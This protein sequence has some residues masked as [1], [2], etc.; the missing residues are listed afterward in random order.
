MATEVEEVQSAL[1]KARKAGDD[2]AVTAL[3]RYRNRIEQRVEQA[4]SPAQR[5]GSLPS[6]RERPKRPTR[7]TRQ[8]QIEKEAWEADS[9]LPRANP[10]Q[11]ADFLREQL[12]TPPAGSAEQW[13]GTNINR[14]IVMDP[15][16]GGARW[17]ALS[18]ERLAQ[19]QGQKER[20]KGV[21]AALKS[22]FVK[23]TGEAVEVLDEAVKRQHATQK[24]IFMQLS[25]SAQERVRDTLKLKFPDKT[26]ET[27]SPYDFRKV[28]E[29]NPDNA[30][31]LEEMVGDERSVESTEFWKRVGNKIL[32]LRGGIPG[33]MDFFGADDP[34]GDLIGPGSFAGLEY[35][36]SEKEP[37]YE[38]V[39][40]DIRDWKYEAG[41]DGVDLYENMIQPFF[42]KDGVLPGA[43]IQAA[44]DKIRALGYTPGQRESVE[45]RFFP[46]GKGLEDIFT[47]EMW[48]D[49]NT[50]LPWNDWDGFLLTVAENA[51]QI[52]VG[53]AASYVGGGVAARLSVNATRGSKLMEI[54]KARRRAAGLGG[55]IAGG[56]TEGI[57]IHDNVAAEVRDALDEVPMAK[58]EA[59]TKFQQL[60]TAG[61]TPEEAKQ[62]LVREAAS[63]AG[64]AAF[65]FAGVMAGSPMGYF[66]GQ[67][68]A[69]RIGGKFAAS[70]IAI[71]ALGEPFQEGIQ[72][73]IEGEQSD[74]A[75]A[76]IDP[77]NPIFKDKNRRL[78]RFAGGFFIS[79][80][81][82][83]GALGAIEPSKPAGLSKEDQ[84]VMEKTHA[85]MTAADERYKHEIRIS[86][87]AY[88]KATAPMQRLAD[89]EKLEK[90]QKKEAELLLKAEPAMRTYFN[91]EKTL[92]S[93]AETKM[94]NALKMRANATLTD[95]AVA[96]TRRT[97]VAEMV[98]EQQ[99]ILDERARIQSEVG[100][101][102]LRL[103]DVQRLARN[104]EKVQN[105]E[106][107]TEENYA[108]LR[109][110][111]YGTWRGPNKERFVIL[112]KGKRALNL[113][114]QQE[115]NLTGKL[116]AGF[117]GEEKRTPEGALTRELVE[118]AGPA[119]RD[120][121]LYTD[122]LT[123]AGNRRAFDE[124]QKL[125]GEVV[126]AVDV[127]S[128]AWINDNMTHASGDRALMSIAD[129]LAKQKGVKVYRVG[130]DEFA[131]TGASEE[132]VET[133]LQ[134]AADELSATPVVAEGE[135]VTPQITW[136]KGP[137]YA[138]ADVQA[139]SMKADRVRR[140]IIAPRKAKPATHKVRAQ[141]PLLQRTL[142]RL[143]PGGKTKVR[144]VAG[145]Q[146]IYSQ[147]NTDS[148]DVPT[149]LADV[150]S[151]DNLPEVTTVNGVNYIPA[152]WVMRQV[153]RARAT[154]TGRS[155][156]GNDLLTSVMSSVT[157]NNSV[158]DEPGAPNNVLSD[159]EQAA[160][161]EA[162]GDDVRGVKVQNV[163]TVFDAINTIASKYNLYADPAQWRLHYDENIYYEE[164][165]L[166]NRWSSIRDEV[167]RGDNV[168]VLT[169]DGAIQAVVTNVSRRRKRPRVTV[170]IGGRQF[171]F[172]PLR[173]HLITAQSSRADIAWITGDP[174]YVQPDRETIPQ[175][176]T[177]V[178]I[179]HV[180]RQGDWYADLGGDYQP[181][182]FDTSTSLDMY[183]AYWE[184]EYPEWSRATPYVY[185]APE[186]TEEEMEQA[187]TVLRKITGGFKNLPEI[188]LVGSIEEL[189]RINPE[190]VQKLKD[191]PGASLNSVRGFFDE[192][193]PDNGVVILVQN[194]HGEGKWFDA[195]IA[196]TIFHELIG[197]YGVRGVFGNEAEM[198][199]HMHSIVDAFPKVAKR[200]AGS[201]PRQ[202]GQ[203]DEEYKQLLG[204]EM[205]AYITGEML[206]GTIELT[207]PQRTVIQRFFDWI[208]EWFT[209]HG[210]GNYFPAPDKDNLYGFWTD[211]K[212]QMLI[213][214]AQ[215]FVRN[216]TGWSFDYLDGRHVMLMRDADI[217]QLG[218]ITAINT[219]T[220]KLSKGERT[221]LQKKYPEGQVA[222][223][224][225]PLFP[226]I[227]SPNVWKQ[228]VIAAFKQNLM[229]NKELELTKLQEKGQ[230]GEEA[231]WNFFTDVTYS[232]IKLLSGTIATDP[233]SDVVQ[234]WYKEVMPFNLAEEFEELLAIVQ[235]PENYVRPDDRAQFV[236]DAE[237]RIAEILSSKIDQKKSQLSRAHLMA[238][239]GSD[240]VVTV[241]VIPSEGHALLNQ[242]QASERLFGSEKGRN[243]YGEFDLLNL[244]EV[245]QEMVKHEINASRERGYDIGFDEDQQEWFD[246]AQRHAEYGG[247]T[248]E[249]ANFAEDYRVVFIKQRG[250][251]LQMGGSGHFSASETVGV[252][253]HV[254]TGLAE[255]LELEGQ[256]MPIAMH[257]LAANRV[258]S[259]VEQQS[260]WLQSLRKSYKNEDEKSRA[261]H[262]K[263]V[264]AASIRSANKEM[265]VAVTA[266]F[267]ARLTEMLLP[268]ANLPEGSLTSEFEKYLL[269]SRGENVTDE[270]RQD[271]YKTFRN[272]KVGDVLRVID[273]MKAII[274]GYTHNRDYPLRG[275][276]GSLDARAFDLL[277]KF[278][279]GEIAGQ[280]WSDLDSLVPRIRNLENMTDQARFVDWMRD[281]VLNDSLL[282]MF[283]QGMLSGMD[284]GADLRLPKA[285]HELH[286][287][288]TEFLNAMGIADVESKVDSYVESI[289]TRQKVT[290]KIPMERLH[291][292]ARAV[293]STPDPERL[294]KIVDEMFNHANLLDNSVH[295]DKVKITVTIAPSGT[296][297]DVEAIGNP[298][299][300][301]ELAENFEKIVHS[302][303]DKNSAEVRERAIREQ[304]ARILQ[305][306]TQSDDKPAVRT[307]GA[308]NWNDIVDEWDIE[309]HDTNDRS[310]ELDDHGVYS[311]EE[312]EE[313]NLDEETRE[314]VRYE[315]DE[316]TDWS[317]V[318]NTDGESLARDGT[319]YRDRVE[320]DEDGDVDNSDAE[321]WVTEQRDE[322]E[323]GLYEEDWVREQAY[324]RL[325]STWDDAPSMLWSGEMPVQWDED[326]DVVD[327]VPIVL[328]RENHD[329]QIELLIDGDNQDTWHDMNDAHHDA[330]RWIQDWYDSGE[331][332][333][334]EGAMFGP[335]SLEPGPQKAL[336]LAMDEVEA[337]AERLQNMPE[338][339]WDV[340]KTGLT[341]DT[342]GF[343]GKDE[344]TAKMFEEL[345]V[346]EK[347]H[348]VSID[349]PLKEDK[350]WRTMTLKYL[351]ADAV[352]RG[353][354]GVVWNPGLATNARGGASFDG[355]ATDRITWTL[356]EIEIAGQPEEVWVIRSPQMDTP[357]VVA[358][359]HAVPVLGG[360]VAAHIMAQINGTLPL[361]PVKEDAEGNTLDDQASEADFLTSSV[362]GTDHVV[363]HDRMT[364]S[365][366]GILPSQAE[367]DAF[368]E[369]EVTKRNDALAGQQ[370]VTSIMGDTTA[371]ESIG[372]VK[373]TGIVTR[374]DMGSQIRI[375]KGQ[376]PGRYVHT[377]GVPTLA[378][379]RTSYEEINPRHWNKELKKHGVEIG[380]IYIRA[381]NIS[382]AEELQ[383]AR[384]KRTDERDKRIAED[385]GS[386]E[387]KELT[388]G[389]HGWV[390]VS[391][392]Q[393]VVYND[394]YANREAAENNLK[395]YI[396]DN[397]GDAGGGV[398]VAYIP[399]N[400]S[401]REEYSGP[402]PPFH[403]DPMDDP[404]L[405]DAATK[406]G[407]EKITLR[408]KW[409]AWRA[410]W[411]D[412]FLQGV[413][414]RFHGIKR[415]L[416]RAGANDIPYMKARLTTSLD[417]MMKAVMEYGYPVWSEGIMV[418][419][420][421]GLLE[422]L[423]PI[424]NDVKLW[425]LYM[426]GTRAKRLM[427]EGYD[428]LSEYGKAKI[429]KAA[430]HFK[431]E[432]KDDKIIALLAH[433]EG[434]IPPMPGVTR[435][436]FM[437][438]LGAVGTALSM[439]KPGES[440]MDEKS[441]EMILK[442][443]REI[444]KPKR[445][446]RRK[447]IRETGRIV[448][449][450]SW[451]NYEQAKFN[452]VKRLMEEAGATR[453]EAQE[454]IERVLNKALGKQELREQAQKA[455]D[456]EGKK[457]TDRDKD[458]QDA[459]Q[460]AEN[461]RERG[462]EHH[463]TARNIQSQVKLGEKYPAFKRVAADYAEFN[464][465]V[466]DFAEEAGIINAE[467]RP[468]WEHADYVPFY[469]VEDDRLVGPMSAGIGI[470]N[471]KPLIKRLSGA[472][473]NVGDITHNIFVNLTKLIDSAVKNDAAV[474]AVDALRGSGIVSKEPMTVSQQLIGLNQVKKLLIE[475]GMNPD[476]IPEDALVG[477]QKMFAIQAPEGPGVISIL[478]N[479][480]K[481][482][483][484]TDDE[485]LYRAMSAINKK[486]WG[487]WMNLFRAPKRLLT[488]LVTLDPGFMIANFIRDSMSAFVL[489]RDRYIPIAGA[490]KGFG[491][492][493]VK[494]EAMRTMLSAGGA[495]E[496]GYINQYDPRATS[497]MIKRE[498]KNKSFRRT[499]LTSPAKLFEA[500]KAI[501]SA[502]E[503]ANRIAVYNAAIR[504][505]KSKLQAAYEAKD[506]MDFSMG[507]DWPFVQFLIQTVPF[508]GARMQG[509]HRLGRGFIENP[510]AFT[511]KGSL[512]GMAGLA[513][514]FAFRDD[515]RYKELE[516]WDKDTYF[517]FWIGD[518][519]YRLP[520]GFEVGALFNTVPE[521]MFEYMYSEENDAGKLLMKRWAFMMAETFNFNPMPQTFRP[522]IES[523][524]NY[525]FFTGRG[526]VSPYEE[527][528]MAPEEYR[529]LSSPSMIELARALPGGLDT[530]SAKIRSPLHLENLFR[531]YT[532][533]LGRYFMMA[534]DE[535]VRSQMN[536][537]LRPEL[538]T[539][540]YPVTG[541]FIR[542]DEPR[543]T[544]YEQEV[545]TLIRKTTEIQGSLRFLAKTKQLGRFE[546][547]RTE[548]E[549]YIRV[550]KKL[551]DVRGQVSD[552][553]KAIMKVYVDENM[554]PKD[555]RKKIDEWQ[556]KKN[557]LF[558]MGYGLRPGG[559]RN[560][561]EGAE[562]ITQEQIE[563]LIE[564]FGVDEEQS[565]QLEDANPETFDLLTSVDGLGKSNLEALAKM[566]G[567]Q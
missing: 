479:G 363:V 117:T 190:L 382:R 212:I 427:L 76:S 265:A 513:L 449:P 512:I 16:T 334:P 251:G 267:Q 470:A 42:T 447:K 315:I 500:W 440:A 181:D 350:Y 40:K 3:E 46:E 389:H 202:P 397:Y 30:K 160:A 68:G 20:A 99:K 105:L 203:S 326:G 458:I 9:A 234:D 335:T 126:A 15:A 245:E 468:M 186:A 484:Y 418:T 196:E 355:V 287:F 485:I 198:R 244:D 85:Y 547:I 476:S 63:S 502:A 563:D 301:E 527:K 149:K 489:S 378:G 37:V 97:T 101:S 526:I 290:Y 232:D 525:N 557:Q 316:N 284:R 236:L 231:P 329:E 530:A 256:Q 191:H 473:A 221:Q 518:N 10:Q 559:E 352:R 519:H 242:E 27:V 22:G 321:R 29:E 65:V 273:D 505:G 31:V 381:K 281:E 532:G 209:R 57:L 241:T 193:H 19:I 121:L 509:L 320:I 264:I 8:Q 14:D 36:E 282:R 62:V 261:E 259:L 216:G 536:Y 108:E 361:K 7:P 155:S 496:S 463:F 133:A 220:K 189:Q 372:E 359:R 481:E 56:T 175:I 349:T 263:G 303:I 224:E 366:M 83:V 274:N 61:F 391:E 159:I 184:T 396:Q 307:D 459:S 73:V 69:G 356:E 258:L 269:E 409:T 144:L 250:G 545:Y 417:S 322:Y 233:N 35:N 107:L 347:R 13:G 312:Y 455:A 362:E 507:G 43:R 299:G 420:G 58:Y 257:E 566:T 208:R 217:F 413:P 451:K 488:T 2:D 163:N 129:I 452:W 200:R 225:V 344:S 414:N 477:F 410:S 143:Q 254:R 260:D 223:K 508:M 146:I 439:P 18:P 394:I 195:K 464:K 380:E 178:R 433:L 551:E 71:G 75:I 246:R 92:T 357:M 428:K 177:D 115:R 460:A 424:M 114:M 538:R 123:G 371:V 96:R 438:G 415:A 119:E 116:T 279:I 411:K 185:K 306:K 462:R 324:E 549:P 445:A 289:Q 537:P 11:A 499:L 385:H 294:A 210:W 373:M 95:I 77:D 406:I 304:R 523:Y 127:D 384:I 388:G 226:E 405:A 39:S 140:R 498:M 174:E 514:W 503:N 553:N 152:S 435:R 103:E 351:L 44:A 147:K 141:L 142:K 275:I 325:R 235:S 474:M 437:E 541:R 204:E 154:F 28:M 51:A 562:P 4:E 565:A 238:F 401:I 486:A 102:I 45:K 157:I 342:K 442:R 179:G 555:K 524:F 412:N 472:E 353:L 148:I 168:E 368:I 206:A 377:F 120:R 564:N 430:E 493:L 358:K 188:T 314:I 520:K 87:P 271:A 398:K 158:L 139:A 67:A 395:S 118:R 354:P 330:H 131:V 511:M 137:T 469:R 482:F 268:I 431:G 313:S 291:D 214:R 402:V 192:V 521:R 230:K 497:R 109:M 297:I 370:Q 104:I 135:Q 60:L 169:P 343:P 539:G 293:E 434:Y 113:L 86:D 211:E 132:V 151:L 41:S 465:K 375:I 567:A 74:M 125:D 432:T 89:M 323:Q 483:Y 237:A 295:P 247:S 487:R 333:P 213:T 38:G 475:R 277:D 386:L 21:K 543:R 387:I 170:S 122:H 134:A 98:E 529:Y 53:V 480:K 207:P 444:I 124:R 558:E 12:E 5:S 517:H 308:P 408:E 253:V 528:R 491:Q 341:V 79:A 276:P 506:L 339:N 91:N 419:E 448:D 145:E 319:D 165:S 219:A 81:T 100:Q 561:I 128:L 340:V 70:K 522:M 94:L 288:M 392:T 510:V 318:T 262:R 285:G 272:S 298:S 327:T 550:A 446:G 162:K 450:R 542:G 399:I 182:L 249:G 328:K 560:L 240:K 379:A 183:G 187:R 239:L 26:V 222:P 345:V 201:V 84:N 218:T 90:L 112:P 552:I 494:D 161:R 400:D 50:K 283:N 80:P 533:T 310:T 138:D 429:D 461:L 48:T 456:E 317:E 383:G 227:G 229:T 403:Y 453:A 534:A 110:E 59:D 194:I 300:M 111:G 546:N 47:A 478:R 556:E 504:A 305:R 332:T 64:K 292:Y 278:A 23:M 302:W 407:Y 255:V 205:I 1:E 457:Q 167:S 106:A 364:G 173:N 54:E 423:R 164:P 180:G 421:R 72:E 360:D 78:E 535:M 346:L 88:I 404:D 336:P 443:I 425:D 270:E 367:A 348:G 82:A 197:H 176:I 266:E 393:G 416:S 55:V 252:L 365:M 172:N 490:L 501:G 516:D 492:A 286:K 309:E 93:E 374:D 166:P 215:D 495:F 130:G 390:I 467:T 32:S 49:P 338:P 52:G 248:P 17:S 6:N 25:P 34:E 426:S 436:E 150:I 376:N 136:G 228:A 331:I 24:A 466:L 243:E 548:F 33:T 337:E 471:Q 422:I 199:Q 515:D 280:L 369:L 531:G 441:R 454:S 66:F 544:R 554:D 156:I 311:Y 153:N 540:D 171:T 296:A